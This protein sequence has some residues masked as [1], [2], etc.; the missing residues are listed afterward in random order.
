[1]LECDWPQH[2][3]EQ[4]DAERTGASDAGANRALAGSK[5][6]SPRQVVRRFRS[7]LAF[8]EA[9]PNNRLPDERFVTNRLCVFVLKS[10]E[11]NIVM[12]TVMTI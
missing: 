2:R 8:K 7:R 12:T 6:G 9:A 5:D 4:R 1:M 3:K 11:K 10:K